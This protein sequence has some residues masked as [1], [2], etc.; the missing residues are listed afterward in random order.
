MTCFYG[1]PRGHINARVANIAP[2]ITQ[3]TF[4]LVHYTLLINQLQ[5]GLTFF[6]VLANFPTDKYGLDCSLELKV[7][8]LRW[9]T[10]ALWMPN[11]TPNSK[12]HSEFSNLKPNSK[13]SHRI[14]EPYSKFKN[15]T[16]NS[17]IALRIPELHSK[18]Q[19]L[20]SNSKTSLRIKKTH[21]EL[22]NSIRIRKAHSEF[23]NLI[24]TATGQWFSTTSTQIDSQNLFQP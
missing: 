9:P 5:F 21:S 20:T 7:P 6:K 12:L 17:K 8:I 13:T 10:S 24:Y 4:K 14:L 19:N 1:D 3:V 15:L 2:C 16:P 23:L 18:F 22:K 11:D